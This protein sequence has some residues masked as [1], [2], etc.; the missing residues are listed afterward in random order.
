M[1]LDSRPIYDVPDDPQ[2]HSER[3]KPRLP[4]Q[5]SLTA[6][7]SLIRYISHPDL[8]MNRPFVQEWVNHVNDLVAPGNPDLFLCP[9]SSGGTIARK[10]APFPPFA[11]ATGCPSALAAVGCDR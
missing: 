7:F 6:P 3:R 8:E 9:L 2:L 5:L 1:L 11:G 10:C 4:L